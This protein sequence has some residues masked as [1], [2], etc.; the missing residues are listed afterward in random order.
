MLYTLLQWLSAPLRY[1][2]RLL[3]FHRN[4]ALDSLIANLD[5]E[6][7]SAAVTEANKRKEE[8]RRKMEER[9]FTAEQIAEANAAIGKLCFEVPELPLDSDSFV[10]SFDLSQVDEF[11]EFYERYGFVILRD[12]LNKEEIDASVEEIWDELTRGEHGTRKV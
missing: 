7:I 3:G 4:S 5:G 8:I 9:N 6:D 2:L 11:L 12:I 10:Q 1:L